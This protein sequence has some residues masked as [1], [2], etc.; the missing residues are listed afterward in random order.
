MIKFTVPIYKKQNNKYD[1]LSKY[2]DNMTPVDEDNACSTLTSP[3]T[4]PQATKIGVSLINAR[5]R[6][7]QTGSPAMNLM[8]EHKTGMP[9]DKTHEI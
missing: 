9:V 6:R 3:M 2:L 5:Y 7:N 1:M 4:M 8:H